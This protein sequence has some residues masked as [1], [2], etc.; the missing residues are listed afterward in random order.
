MS[1]ANGRSIDGMTFRSLTYR[2]GSASYTGYVADGSRGHKVPG[3][4]VAHEGGGFLT[5]HAKDRARMVA[6]LG[7]VAF[8]LDLFGDPRPTLDEARQMVQHLRNDLPTLRARA[9][10]ALDLLRQQSNVDVTRLAAI[11]FCFGGHNS[12]R[13]CPERR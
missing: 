13:A 9:T 12:V 1:H 8:A 5:E 11:G 2:I 7:Y 3:V 6:E 4:L 10:R